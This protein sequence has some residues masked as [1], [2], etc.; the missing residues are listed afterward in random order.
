MPQDHAHPDANVLERAFLEQARE[1]L[2]RTSIALDLDP[3][4]QGHRAGVGL[5]E[6]KVRPL[7]VGVGT[8]AAAGGAGEGGR[9]ACV[10]GGGEGG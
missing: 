8:A 1:A 4:G 7:A 6:N 9:S 5:V 3:V 10:S 2:V